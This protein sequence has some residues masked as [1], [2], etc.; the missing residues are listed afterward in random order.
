MATHH[1]LLSAAATMVDLWRLQPEE[2]VYAP[3]P[4]FHLSVVGSVLGPM[5][6]GGTGV[7]EKGFSVQATWEQVRATGRRG[8][9]WPGP[10]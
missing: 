6:A 2:V 3:L 1:Y 8:W 5:L 10:W 4:L 7:L 9:P